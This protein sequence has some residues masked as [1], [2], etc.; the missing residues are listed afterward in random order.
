[1][2]IMV[3]F[4]KAYKDHM[5]ATAKSNIV[6]A[7]GGVVS[8]NGLYDVIKDWKDLILASKSEMVECL[9][10]GF[11]PITLDGAYNFGQLQVI[12]MILVQLYGE[13]GTSPRFG[14]LI[15]KDGAAAF[16]DMLL[17]VC[18]NVYAV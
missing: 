17:D 4:E 16:L 2:A 9:I 10:S 8:Y 14:W 6:K 15:D 5:E 12:W 13:Y 7:I 3:K 11:E 1:M 18:D